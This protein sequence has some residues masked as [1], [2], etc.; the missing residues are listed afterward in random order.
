[1]EKITGYPLKKFYEDPYFGFKIV[2]PEDQKKMSVEQTKK[3]LE[4]KIR[5]N[6]KIL[7]NHKL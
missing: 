2:H 7:I 4:E 3:T 1:M 5:M 6:L